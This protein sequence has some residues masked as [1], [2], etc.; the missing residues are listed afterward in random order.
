MSEAFLDFLT[1]L[2]EENMR[3]EL[4]KA[5]L[6]HYGVS[7]DAVSLVRVPLPVTV[8][9]GYT[10]Y[11]GGKVLGAALNRYLYLL[12]RKRSD[13]TA[14]YYDLRSFSEKV[15]SL[16]DIQSSQAVPSYAACFNTVITA[17]EHN[18][19]HCDTGFELLIFNN[20]PIDYDIFSSSALKT[21]FAQALIEAFQFSVEPLALAK[22]E[23]P[24][25]EITE[26]SEVLE[27]TANHG[28]SYEAAHRISLVMGKRDHMLLTDPAA[29]EYSA[30]QLPPNEYAC[31][32]MRPHIRTLFFTKHFYEQH[33][34]CMDAFHMLQ[35]EKKIQ[36]LCDVTEADISWLE[37]EQQQEQTVKQLR[38]WVSEQER[39]QQAA[40]AL[41]EGDFVSFGRCMREGQAALQ[42]LYEID[43]QNLAL[44]ADTSNAHTACLGACIARSEAEACVIALVSKHTLED[45]I[46]QIKKQYTEQTGYAPSVLLCGI[47][48]GIKKQRL[49]TAE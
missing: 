20:F 5:F 4:I 23:Q 43:E 39:V 7:T 31:V 32:M 37:T 48:G 42:T 38:Y 45:F 46:V 14:A 47:S 44:L 41:R 6:L 1:V 3:K 9:G 19:L 11:G 36:N 29:Y 10:E 8:M 35:Q 12:I 17:F 15:H 2:P 30:I 13:S 27:N 18:G 16:S 49:E 34:A 33:H 25:L 26:K 40:A 28:I 22:M 24:A 21:G